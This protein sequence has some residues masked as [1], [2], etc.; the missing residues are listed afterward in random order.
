MVKVGKIKPNFTRCFVA[1]C[2]ELNNVSQP[3]LNLLDKFIL[4]QIKEWN[5]L[6]NVTNIRNIFTLPTVRH[7]EDDNEIIILI[8]FS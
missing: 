3:D 8:R 2:D 5:N 4:Q 6:P 1:S 7:N